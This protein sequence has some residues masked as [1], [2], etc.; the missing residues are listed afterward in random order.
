MTACHMGRP[1]ATRAASICPP[2]TRQKTYGRKEIRESPSCAAVSPSTESAISGLAIHKTRQRTRAEAA[3][4][5]VLRTSSAPRCGDSRRGSVYRRAP[6]MPIRKKGTSVFPRTQ[7][8]L[9][10]PKRSGAQARANRALT[11]RMLPVVATRPLATMAARR[12][13]PNQAFSA[14]RSRKAALPVSRLQ[15]PSTILHS[16]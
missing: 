9:N 3:S 14:S 1:D 11:T 16:P 2:A 6:G 4:T 13:R 7:I 15:M 5:T 10:W 12:E 8:V